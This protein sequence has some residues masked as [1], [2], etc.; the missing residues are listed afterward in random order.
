MYVTHW[1]PEFGKPDCGFT[2]EDKEDED[3]SKL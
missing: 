3:E 2:Y 1:L